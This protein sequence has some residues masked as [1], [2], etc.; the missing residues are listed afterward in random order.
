MKTRKFAWIALA[1]VVSAGLSAQSFD[2]LNLKGTRV[3]YW[4]Q[5]TKDTEKAFQGLIERFNATNGWGITVSGEYAGNYSDIYNKMTAGIA[6]GVTPNLVVAYQN[7]AAGYMLNGGIVDL[8]P[9]V[10]DAKYGIPKKDLADYFP[11]FITQD[12]SAQFGGKRLGWP[13]NR[14]IEVMYYNADWLKALG[15]KAPPA[16]WEDFALACKKATDPAAGTSGYDIST[17]ASNVFA[18]VIGRGGDIQAPGGK[19]YVFNTKEM[20]DSLTF[21]KKLYADGYAKKIGEPY[22]EQTDFANKKVLFTMGSSSGLPYYYSSIKGAAKGSF[23]WS[24]AAIPHTT[25]NPM[26][27]IYG[28]S[29]SLVK[30]TPEKQLA[31]WLF[32]R[33]MSEPKQ[34]ADWVRAANYFPVRVSTAESLGDYFAKNAQYA[35]AFELLK[36]GSQKG[37]PP[38]V[39]YDQVRDA[40]TSAYNAVLDGADIDATLVQL[41]TKANKI[42]RDAAP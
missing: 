26:C 25:A 39:G 17:D 32:L 3:T 13:P 4:Y 42:F 28:A 33:W 34:Q 1:V 21:M 15:F 7:Q 6:G 31:S 9:Y 18:Q 41:E 22:G 30:S 23:N 29:V 10:N 37:E 11:G 2:S 40:V 36:S 12:V 24:V 27:N 19:G 16:T 5:F 8:N 35:D 38:Y 14:S 20:R